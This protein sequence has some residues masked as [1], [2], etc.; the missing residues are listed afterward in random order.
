MPFSFA[1]L[2]KGTTVRCRHALLQREREKDIF[3]GNRVWCVIT[4]D[5]LPI[6]LANILKVLIEK[7]FRLEVVVL[8]AG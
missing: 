5:S 3:E 8:L 2:L 4:F 7:L 6:M 1:L